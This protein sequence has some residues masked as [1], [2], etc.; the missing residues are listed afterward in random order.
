M[1]WNPDSKDIEKFFDEVWN[2][3][4]LLDVRF[5]AD[6]LEWMK[7]GSNYLGILKRLDIYHRIPNNK[8]KY[9]LSI[10]NFR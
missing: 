3:F 9:F 5:L 2:N 8:F 6:I 1:I 10:L 7:A 4:R